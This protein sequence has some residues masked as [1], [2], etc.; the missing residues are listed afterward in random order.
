M[1][2]TETSLLE[3]IRQLHVMNSELTSKNSFLQK[4]NRDLKDYIN[5]LLEDINNQETEEVTYKSLSDSPPSAFVDPNKNET[6]TYK[7]LRRK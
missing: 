3:M 7:K 2:D 4:E 5:Q 6:V 1:I